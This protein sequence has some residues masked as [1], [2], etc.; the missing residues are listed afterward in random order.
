MALAAALA[1]AQQNGGF[2]ERN[3]QFDQNGDGKID[4]SERQAVREKMRARGSK[5]D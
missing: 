3:Q 4:D 1:F 2:A 5:A